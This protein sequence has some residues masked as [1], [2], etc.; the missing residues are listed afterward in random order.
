MEGVVGRLKIPKHPWEQ[1]QAEASFIIYVFLV[2]L[3]ESS[4]R[5]VFIYTSISYTIE[6]TSG[7][8]C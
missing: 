8:E 3:L 7:G 1:I 6:T 4:R 2:V 5:H